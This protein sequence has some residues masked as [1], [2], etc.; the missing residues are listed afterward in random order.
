MVEAELSGPSG[1]R[2]TGSSA[3]RPSHRS[4]VEAPE[5]C[6]LGDPGAQARAHTS[7]RGADQESGDLEQVIPE[8]GRELRLVVSDPSDLTADP[9]REVERFLGP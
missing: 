3:W 2:R 1:P 5:A 7:G 8:L 9:K 6:A 4:T